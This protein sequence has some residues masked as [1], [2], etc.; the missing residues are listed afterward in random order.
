MSMCTEGAAFDNFTKFW[1]SDWLAFVL[2]LENRTILRATY[3]S[4]F[5][6]SCVL[7]PW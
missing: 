7:L 5:I 3:T 2:G 6:A 1:M 4:R